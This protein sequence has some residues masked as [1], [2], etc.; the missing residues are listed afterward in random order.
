MLG[1]VFLVSGAQSYNIETYT[2][3][4]EGFLLSRH[5]STTWQLKRLI[6][7]ERNARH[8]PIFRNSACYRPS[9]VATGLEDEPSRYAYQDLV[10]GKCP[11]II[12]VDV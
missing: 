4:A 12:Y 5:G 3:P 10:S 9:N 8:G 7:V 6:S 2:S 1:N 11:D